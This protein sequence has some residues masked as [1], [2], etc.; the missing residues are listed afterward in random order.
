MLIINVELPSVEGVKTLQVKYNPNPETVMAEC[1]RKLGVS[2]P[3][4]LCEDQIDHAE[5]S[6]ILNGGKYKL[7]P[8]YPKGTRVRASGMEKKPELNG[9]EGVVIVQ[10]EG[11]YGVLFDDGVKGLLSVG[12]ITAI[13]EKAEIAKKTFEKFEKMTSGYTEGSFIPPPSVVVPVLS[14]DEQRSLIVQLR[15]EYPNCPVR[16]AGYALVSANWDLESA[17]LFL[18]PDQ[19]APPEETDEVACGAMDNPSLRRVAKDDSVG[20]AGTAGVM[21]SCRKCRHKLFTSAEVKPHTAGEAVGKKE[22]KKKNGQDRLS[23]QDCGSIFIE[24]NSLDWLT[25]QAAVLR[26]DIRC[27]NTKCGAKI[28][29]YNWTGQQCSCGVWVNPA[30][31]MQQS[32]MDR[33][34]ISE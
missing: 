14:R 27:P 16:A 5:A 11:R 4:V 24:E 8:V 6:D 32:K 10:K 12:N 25:E 29:L 33:F 18:T 15:K 26:D 28:G 20:G 31:M 17:H 7:V 3:M 23:F 9:K 13:D 22:F 30:L 34:A 2:V 21:Y 19:L 1:R